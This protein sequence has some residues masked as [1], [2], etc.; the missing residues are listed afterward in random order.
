MSGLIDKWMQHR[1]YEWNSDLFVRKK[2]RRNNKCSPKQAIEAL[3]FVKERFWELC[4]HTKIVSDEDTYVVVQ[5]KINGATLSQLN[6]QN[7]SKT[8]LESL[9][10]FLQICEWILLE[11]NIEFDI[12]GYQGEEIKNQDGNPW[13]RYDDKFL[14]SQNWISRKYYLAINTVLYLFY[15]IKSLVKNFSTSIFESSNLMI[16][17]NKG[18]FLVDNIYVQNPWGETIFH[19]LSITR[20]LEN[21]I[22]IKYNQ[23][24]VKQQLKKLPN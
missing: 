2:Q 19:S 18:L 13:R 8:T 9:V 14:A 21:Y 1:V 23:F 20:K 10:R 5:R 15:R 7:L 11:E 24:K 3:D 4:P 17:K 22:W 6:T 16:D 12:L